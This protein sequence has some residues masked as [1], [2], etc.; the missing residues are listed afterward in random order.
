MM[1]LVSEP[2]PSTLTCA[3]HWLESSGGLRAL[4]ERAHCHSFARLEPALRLETEADAKR[5]PGEDHRAG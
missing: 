2:I 1:G 3:S 4:S 5:S